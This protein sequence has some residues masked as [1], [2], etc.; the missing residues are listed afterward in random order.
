MNPQKS[1]ALKDVL[2]ISVLLITIDVNLVYP[3]FN[4]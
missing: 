1:L 4:S 3:F 2:V